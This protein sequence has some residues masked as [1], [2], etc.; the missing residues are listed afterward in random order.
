MFHTSH[1]T[2]RHDTITSH[3][4]GFPHSS[5]SPAPWEPCTSC[6]AGGVCAAASLA[7]TPHVPCVRLLSHSVVFAYPSAVGSTPSVPFPLHCIL[8]LLGLICGR[9]A[10]SS[11]SGYT[12]A[13][14]FREPACFLC[15]SLLGVC[16]DGGFGFRCVLSGWQSWWPPPDAQVCFVPSLRGQVRRSGTP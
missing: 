2:V 7:P 12:R 10:P 15:L 8:G 5:L 6:P 13:V 11:G 16:S 9:L 3:P 1:V 4:E 14:A